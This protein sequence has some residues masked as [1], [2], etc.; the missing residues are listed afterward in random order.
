MKTAMDV[1]NGSVLWQDGRF[2]HA[3]DLYADGKL[4]I[5]NEDAILCLATPTT[6]GLIVHARIDILTSRPWTAPTLVGRT[7][8][9]RDRKNIIALQL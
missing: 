5:F 2:S 6:R 8:R 1:K 9:L 7:L 4:I 3:D